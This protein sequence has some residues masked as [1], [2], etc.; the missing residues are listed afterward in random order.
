MGC[1]D[2]VTD[3]TSTSSGF[4]IFV[5]FDFWFLFQGSLKARALNSWQIYFLW[6]KLLKTIRVMWTNWN[7]ILSMIMSLISLTIISSSLKPRVLF[8]RLLRLLPKK[9]RHWGFLHRQTFLCWG[10]TNG[11]KVKLMHRLWGLELGS[12]FVIASLSLSGWSNHTGTLLMVSNF[13]SWNI[14]LYNIF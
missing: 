2:R 4:I 5:L 1:T 6:R 7:R 9:R 3:S 13:Q 8:Q 11:F 10:T 12:G 14:T